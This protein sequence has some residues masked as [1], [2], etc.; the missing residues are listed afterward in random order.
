MARR[1]HLCLSPCER[2]MSLAQVLLVNLLEHC[3]VRVSALLP[4]TLQNTGSPIPFATR[5]R[6]LQGFI[7]T[8]LPLRSCT[9]LVVVVLPSRQLHMLSLLTLCFEWHTP[10][11]WSAFTLFTFLVEQSVPSGASRSSTAHALG[12]SI[13]FSI[14]IMTSSPLLSE[15]PKL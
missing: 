9:L 2:C 8:M 11:E 13:L 7:M 5:M 6:Y 1:S 15:R 4:C 10:T 3:S 14:R 12:T